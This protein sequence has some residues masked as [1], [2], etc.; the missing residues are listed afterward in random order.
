MGIRKKKIVYVLGAGPTGLIIA[1]GAKM[2]GCEV[3]VFSRPGDSG[4][5]AKSELHGCQYLH[6][7]VPTPSLAGL[8]RTV[9]YTL[10][11]TVEGYRAKVYGPSWQGRVSPDEYGDEQPHEAWDIRRV[12]DKLWQDWQYRIVPKDLDHT[13][14]SSLLTHG[15]PH[16]MFSTVPAP[17]LC[18]DKDHA[19]TVSGVWA[20]GERDAPSPKPLSPVS[21]EPFTVVCSGNPD[22]GWYRVA[23]VYGYTTVEWPARRKPPIDG[24][25]QVRKPLATNC[26]CFLGHKGFLRVGRF[27]RWQKGVLVHHAYEEAMAAL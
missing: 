23:N 25:V 27:G 16:R 3:L 11:G 20:F 26:D 19:F 9:R 14:V 2:R 10:T 21:C 18:R 5:A 1:E 24:V 22:V 12:Y 6:A 7:P 4:R 13:L 17:A 15:R 8:P